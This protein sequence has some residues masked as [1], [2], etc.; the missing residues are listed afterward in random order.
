MFIISQK[1]GL[2]QWPCSRVSTQTRLK[3]SAL[4]PPTEDSLAAVS[5]PI[6]L[7]TP[8]SHLATTSN[9]PVSHFIITWTWDLINMSQ[10]S[11]EHP[12]ATYGCSVIS[13]LSLILRAANPLSVLL[14]V[15]GL[16]I[17]IHA[18]PTISNKYR[19]FKL[20]CPI[21]QIHQLCLLYLSSLLHAY[22]DPQSDFCIIFGRH[23]QFSGLTTAC[24]KNLIISQL[25]LIAA[26]FRP[27][28]PHP[29]KKIIMTQ[30]CFH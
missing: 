18:Y 28:F 22:T 26:Y 21:R 5:N 11:A 6:Q 4:E 24:Q 17:P 20:P 3:L 25:K 7:L 23:N 1:L 29:N 12:I 30:E 2:S 10:T 16:T 14:S 19:E 27:N 9:Y 8:L 13:P 15:Q